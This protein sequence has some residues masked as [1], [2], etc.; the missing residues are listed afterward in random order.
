MNVEVTKKISG[1]ARIFRG[2]QL[3]VVQEAQRACADI[4]EVADRSRNEIQRS[5]IPIVS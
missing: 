2:D 3:H 1:N 4:F 5:H